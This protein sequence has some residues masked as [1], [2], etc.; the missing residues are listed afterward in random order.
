MIRA[1]NFLSFDFPDFFQGTEHT[2]LAVPVWEGMTYQD[3]NDDLEKTSNQSDYGIDDWFG[4]ERSVEI[5][6]ADTDMNEPIKH[7]EVF[8][9]DE[10]GDETPYAYFAVVECDSDTFDWEHESLS[11]L[12]WVP[13]FKC[14]KIELNREH[15]GIYDKHTD[16][17]GVF[18]VDVNDGRLL[19]T[20]NHVMLQG[21]F[22]YNLLE[23]N[24]FDMGLEELAE[25]LSVDTD[26]IEE[27]ESEGEDMQF[28]PLT[29]D[30]LDSE[31]VDS[32]TMEQLR[33]C[34]NISED[35]KYGDVLDRV[36]EYYKCNYAF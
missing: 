31:H 16:V 2:S 11:D 12:V 35:E 17:H 8:E 13:E 15:F 22:L 32:Y 1:V 10:M 34:L 29:I 14:V 26:F 28:L 30:N 36:Y 5:L 27:L 33:D 21:K 4:W 6:F 24:L 3:L 23:H 9:W 18:L 20:H 25:Y 7:L 19:S